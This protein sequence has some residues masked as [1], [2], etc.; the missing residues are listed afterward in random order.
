M[1]DAYWKKRA[2]EL[3]Q[4][5]HK[6]AH[7]TQGKSLEDALNSIPGL[8]PAP[9]GNSPLRQPPSIEQQLAARI[10]NAIQNQPS[11]MQQAQQHQAPRAQVVFVKEGARAYR[12][13]EAQGYGSNM[14]IARLSGPIQGVQGR[15]FEFKG[16]VEAYILEGDDPVD[17][18]NPNPA[19][20][21]RL[22]VVQAPFIGKFLVSESAVF[23][24][25]GPE[26]SLLKG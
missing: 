21:K 19:Q 11:P 24:G 5:Q 9:T 12:Q 16:I 18:A 8:P 22:A 13:L 14:P 4:Q 15:Q 17:L 20:I 3:E 10:A 7:E 25:T 23:N 6:P 26:R 2:K 1:T